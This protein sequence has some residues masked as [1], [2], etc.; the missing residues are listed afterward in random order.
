M[1]FNFCKQNNACLFYVKS[2]EKGGYAV[3]AFNVYNL[4]GIE[5]VVAAA[6][7]EKSPA[8]LQVRDYCH[9]YAEVNVCIC[10]IL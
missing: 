7:A 5:A 8:I 1:F 3:G 4:E 6:E 9:F 10:C 2:A